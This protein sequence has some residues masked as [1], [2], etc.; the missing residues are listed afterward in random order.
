MQTTLTISESRNEK[1]TMNFKTAS[2]ALALMAF[3]GATLAMNKVEL[4]EAL[5]TDGLTSI[6]AFRTVNAFETC[7]C[8]ALS[9]SGEAGSGSISLPDFGTLDVKG[10]EGMVTSMDGFCDIQGCDVALGQGENDM[11]WKCPR[12]DRDCIGES[13]SFITETNNE[14]GRLVG[15]RL[16]SGISGSMAEIQATSYWLDIVTQL[17]YDAQAGVYDTMPAIKD[18]PVEDGGDSKGDESADEGM[19]GNDNGGKLRGRNLQV[20]V[21]DKDQGDFLLDA[22]NDGLFGDGRF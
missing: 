9:L 12:Q 22:Q 10:P 8:G 6:D 19:N 5:A 7:T 14:C 2:R 3:P 17:A 1:R 13:V 4:I 20:P 11:V 18:P 15:L 16:D 21:K